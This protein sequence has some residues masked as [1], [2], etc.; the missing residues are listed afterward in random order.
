MCSVH[1]IGCGQSRCPQIRGFR[2]KFKTRSMRN[3]LKITTSGNPHAQSH[4][5]GPKDPVFAAV[6]IKSCFSWSKR[7]GTCDYPKN[8]NVPKGAPSNTCLKSATAMLWHGQIHNNW[9][10]E[11]G[12][13]GGQPRKSAPKDVTDSPIEIDAERLIKKGIIP[14]FLSHVPQAYMKAPRDLLEDLVPFTV[15]RRTTVMITKANE[16]VPD[17]PLSKDIFVWV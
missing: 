9:I 6:F 5:K 8:F 12:G 3:R 15:K 17:V 13:A 11:R 1:S 10:E 16:A 2:G 7:T 14:S 4:V